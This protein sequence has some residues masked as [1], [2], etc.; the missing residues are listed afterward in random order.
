MESWWW[1]THSHYATSDFQD[2]HGKLIKNQSISLRSLPRTLAYY[3]SCHYQP[4][5]ISESTSWCSATHS[6]P[7]CTNRMS[8]RTKGLTKWP[9][10]PWYLPS[11]AQSDGLYFASVKRAWIGY[12]QVARRTW[13]ARLHPAPTTYQHWWSR[14]ADTCKTWV[15]LYYELALWPL[16]SLDLPIELG[17]WVTHGYPSKAQKTRKKSTYVRPV[18]YPSWAFHRYP[19]ATGILES[20]WAR[21]VWALA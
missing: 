6:S 3:P 15:H 14:T 4:T 13:D 11:T 5:T 2:R 1:F 17:P 19:W 21:G 16:S 18:C 20:P 12:K 7:P 10:I 9:D 8:M